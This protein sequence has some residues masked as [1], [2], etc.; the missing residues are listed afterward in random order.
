MSRKELL[1]HLRSAPGDQHE[2]LRSQGLASALFPAL[3]AQGVLCCPKGCGAFFDG[4]SQNTSKPLAAHVAANKCRTRRPSRHNRTRELDGPFLPTTMGG[5]QAALADIARAAEA[6]PH[7]QA[8]HAPA[9][10]FCLA[11]P[12]FTMEHLRTSGL[13][14]STA[15]PGPSRALITSTVTSLFR[16]AVSM[17]GEALRSAAWSLVFLFPTLVLGP[18]RPGAASSAVKAETEARID[19]WHRGKL[20]ELAN[21]ALAAKREH[22]P[23]SRSKKAKA[24]RRAAALLRHNQFARAAGLA[25]S[26]GIA[27]ASQDTLDAIPDL[28]KDPEPVAEETLRK[29]YGPRVTPTRESMAVNISQE[30]VL[31]HLAAVAPLTTP[32][33]DGWRAEH[34]LPLCKDQDCGAAFTDLIAALVAGDVTDATCDL[35]SSATLVVLLKK[36]DEEMAALKLKQGPDYK[37]PQRPLGMGSTI[38]KVAANCL[39][40]KVQPAVGASAGPHQFAINAKGGC[41][42][43]QWVLQVIMEAEPDLARSCLDACNAFGDLERPCIRAAL[44]ANVALHPL[45]PLYDVLYTR[46]SGVMWFYDE[47]GNFILAIFG[48]R[49]VRQGCVLGTTILCITIRPV[50]DALLAI[51][52]PEGFLFS[53]ADD[54][55]MGGLPVYVAQAL[56]E[57]VDLYRMVGLTLGW[58]PKKT[59]LVLPIDC[60]PSSLPLPC[61]ISGRPLPEV[62][63]GFKACL[64]VPRHPANDLPFIAEALGAV[65]VRHDNLLD[66]VASVADEDPFGALR[67]LQVCGVNRFGHV[68]SAVPPEASTIFCGQRDAAV[69][70]SLAAIQGSPVDPTQSTHTLPLAAG[71]AGLHSLRDMASASYLG[72]F[73][74]VAGPLISRLAQMGGT[75]T[76]RAATLLEDPPAAR[77]SFAWAR[78][79]CKAHEEALELQSSFTDKELQLISLAAPRG[80]VIQSPGDPS[81]VALDLPPTLDLNITPALAEASRAPKGVRFVAAGLRRLQ[82]WRSF[83]RMHANVPISA[84]PK[85][86]SHSGHGSVT[87]LASDIPLGRRTST[88]LA[89]M[90]IRRICGAPALGDI[91]PGLRS[92]SCPQCGLP[93]GSPEALER[94]VAR[95]P[96]GGARHLM[97]HGL[98]K[99]LRSIVEDSGV[100]KASIVEEA[101][102]MR[103]DDRTRPGDLVVLDFANG[104]RHLIIDGV[105]TTVYRNSIFSKVASI[106][107]YAAK[108]VEDK[109]L[110]AD[111]D[112]PNPVSMCHGGQHTLVPF[113]MEDG[114]R[115]GAHGQAVLRMLAEYAVAKGKLPSLP[116]RAAPLLPPEAVAIWVRRWQQRLSVWLHLTLSRQVMRYLAPS[117]AGGVC[118]S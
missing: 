19:L 34:L 29:L 118:F 85:L 23:G 110:K 116:A 94:H 66:L 57:A 111:A 6:A 7:P 26:K 96:N 60:D 97:H 70:L 40:E 68:L 67:L 48:R 102:G 106:P 88:P 104:G 33:K 10:N 54:V 46:G 37:Q 62:V 20:N 107:G 73:F 39:L 93:A 112:S 59:E 90:T 35:L 79:L 77:G 31:L 12:S 87:V 50:Y 89:R 53:F 95:C 86:L 56:T 101:R 3:L 5:I 105:V 52:G 14:T 108:Q 80:C 43:I 58:G 32:H 114:G 15:V 65:S 47:L 25:D 45:I 113:A 16:Q 109:K 24:A 55:Y 41:D 84:Q 81:S 63:S 103:P 72:A 38:P 74:R 100:P 30:E 91:P 11:N 75:T 17:R 22:P 69:S 78:S 44:E 27:D 64:G 36:S 117:L 92:P 71:G 21:R 13:Q 2:L 18:H 49:G 115:I 42:M 8:P 98:I 28:F 9:I 51:L 4:G 99:T 76:A 61:D 82:D 83:T 1:G